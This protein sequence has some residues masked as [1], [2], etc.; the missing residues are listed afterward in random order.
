[1]EFETLDRCAAYVAARAS[2]Y[3]IQRES[4]RWPKRIANHARRLADETIQATTDALKYVPSSALRRR[5]LRGALGSA[6]ETAAACDAARELGIADEELLRL[7]GRT[8]SL[9]GMLFHAS[10]AAGE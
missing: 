2:A 5:G 8:V 9:L 4:V 1:M 10:A 7:T 6:L 3:A